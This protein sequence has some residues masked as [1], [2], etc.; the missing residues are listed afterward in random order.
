MLGHKIISFCF[1]GKK[2]GVRVIIFGLFI[3]LLWTLWR[4]LEKVNYRPKQALSSSFITVC[5]V[6]HFVVQLFSLRKSSL[7]STRKAS[8]RQDGYFFVAHDVYFFYYHLCYS[9]LFCFCFG[10]F[11]LFVFCFPK[12]RCSLHVACLLTYTS[13]FVIFHYFLYWFVRGSFSK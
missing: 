3:Y 7:F 6:Y 9:L 5:I 11:C 4:R 13:C 1:I 12:I 2:I 10:L 8:K